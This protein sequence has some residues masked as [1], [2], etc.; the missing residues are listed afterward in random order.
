MISCKNKNIAVSF[1]E[2]AAVLVSVSDGIRDYVGVQLP[3]FEVGLRSADGDLLRTTAD[4]FT[5]SEKS[6]TE[7]GFTCT[8]TGKYGLTIRIGMEISDQIQWSL[9]S[10]VAPEYVTEWIQ[11]PQIATPND[12]KDNGGS[13]KI[14]WGFN[15]GALVESVQERQAHFG[16]LEPDYPYVSVMGMFPA[17]VETQFMAYYNQDAGLYFGAHD[18]DCCL[19][20]VDFYPYESGIKFQFRHYCGVEFGGTYTMSYPMVMAFFQGDWYDAADIYRNWFDKEKD[21]GFVPIPENKNLPDWYGESPVVITYPVCGIHDMDERV[22]NKMFPYI[23]VMPHVERLEKEFGSR[24]MVLLMHWEGSAPWAP[25]YVWPPF[26]GEDELKKLIDALHERDDV[27]GVY[28]SGI[29]WTEQSNIVAEYNM[30]KEF[31]ERHLE[32]VMCVSPKQ[33]LPFCNICTAQR[34]GY[35]MCP[36][37]SVVKEMVKKEVQSMVGAGIDYIQ[38]MD[39]NHGGNSHLCYSKNHGHPPVPGKWQVDAMKEFYSE[40]FADTGKALFGC[41]SA[42]GEAYI[43]NLLFSD[44]RYLLN[45][46]IGEPVPAYAYIFHEYVNNFMGNQVCINFFMD[47]EKSPDNLLV[48]TAHAFAAGDM[49]TAVLNQD[50]EITWNWGQLN[51]YDRANLPNQDHI[52]TLIRNLN[53]WR[54]GT[55]KQYLHTGR[56]QKPIPVECGKTLVQT[57]E[58]HDKF[59]D[60]ILVSAWKGLDQTFGQFLINYNTKETSCKLTLPEGEWKLYTNDTDFTTISGGVHEI[61][62]PALSAVLLVK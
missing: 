41:E 20:G 6:T 35:D 33:E 54:R 11:F 23:N 50:G 8:Y 30:R 39:Q 26:G 3:I 31:D 49:L 2:A 24:I 61:T 60:E 14:L 55:G 59:F 10:S 21:A 25:P 52:K 15:E 58:K 43:P 44:N 56:M 29:G 36:T 53:A 40:V 4:E 46:Y 38:L 17:I 12:T 51:D 32:E 16:Y 19:K 7:T 1:D 9:T 27:L 48:R 37:Q 22:P 13:G 45:Y 18:K 42:A 62:V 57:R 28:C 34:S 47:H 5:L